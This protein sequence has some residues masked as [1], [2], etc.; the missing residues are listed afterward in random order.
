MPT[1]GPDPK[2]TRNAEN[3]RQAILNAAET[4]FAE[5][6]Y[7]GARIEAI[8]SASGYNQGL[9]FRYFGD[10]LGLYAEVL[11]RIDRQANEFLGQLLG[12]FLRDDT[13]LTDAGRFKG[14]LTSSIEAFY[15]FMISHPQLMRM[16]LWEQAENWK[17]YTKLAS[18]FKLEGLEAVEAFFAKAQKA[19]LLR[20]DCDPFILFL[21]AEQI[22]WTF[23]T[24]LPFYQMVLPNREF[25]SPEAR[26]Q[27]IDFI[28]GGLMG[29]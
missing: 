5:H 18:L 23:P 8:A 13:L 21:L 19:G 28:I 10:K 20:S 27:V 25:S 2:P 22:C 12:S 9:I 15:D 17:T 1:S 6:G 14:F 16:M 11:R 7:D 29:G 24:S 3:T 26:Q 4:V